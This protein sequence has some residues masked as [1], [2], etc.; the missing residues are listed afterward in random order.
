LPFWQTEAPGRSQA[1]SHEIAELR[2]EIAS[3]M[4][5]DGAAAAAQ[6]LATEGSLSERA[7]TQACDYVR[8]GVAALGVIP[9]EK[10][11][12]V[13]RFFDGLG[14]T[15]LVIHTPFGI[16][17]NRALGLALRKRLCQSFD[18]EI[19]A[20]AIDDGALLALNARH[21]FPI[22]DTLKML[23]ARNARG[24]LEQA[25]LAAPMFEVR[26]RHV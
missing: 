22:E 7:A 20:S 16:R 17:F 2:H 21:S 18:F 8:R 24:V 25:L 6:W 9:D 23:T 11:I 4:H 3:R 15:Q 14:G 19:Q 10:T 26:F 13:E 5:R 1:L 12:V